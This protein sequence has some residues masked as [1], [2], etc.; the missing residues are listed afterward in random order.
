LHRSGS[1]QIR[2]VQTLSIESQFSGVQKMAKPYD[3]EEIDELEAD[4][5][6]DDEVEPD[7]EE[8]EEIPVIAT[9]GGIAASEAAAIVREAEERTVASRQALRE[10][11]E[12]QVAEFLARGGRIQQVDPNVTADP[13]RKPESD[14]G[15]RPI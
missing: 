10:D 11:L 4:G 13:P 5:A 12:R 8:G 6:D 9:G 7:S 2:P 3:D 15:S 14:Y 1:A